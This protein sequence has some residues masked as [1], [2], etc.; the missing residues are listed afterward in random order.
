MC[1]A[2]GAVQHV[3]SEHLGHCRSD[4]VGDDALALRLAPAGRLVGVAARKHDL[5]DR[6]RLRIDPA[7]GE[8]RE[9]RGLLKRRDRFRAER[10]RRKRLEFRGAHAELARHVDDVL[11]ADVERQSRVDG[12]VGLNRR[13]RERL[14]ARVVVCVRLHVPLQRR[15]VERR[16][17][18]VRVKRVDAERDRG[19]EGDR[20][21]RR[22]RLA[23]P[24][25]DEVELVAVGPRSHRGHRANRS[26]ARV[27]R[28]HRARGIGR[29]VQR[30]ADRGSRRT[31][32]PGVNRRVH[33]EPAFAH[34]VRA[35]L[36]LQQILDVAEEVRLA[37]GGVPPSGM[38]VEFPIG[39]RSVVL[40]L[41][42]VVVPEH[43]SKNLIASRES[44]VR[45]NERVV[46][47]R[48]LR[49]AREQRGLV[50]RQ[51][52]RV[53]REVRLRRS[54]DPVRVVA[55]IDLVLVRGEDPVL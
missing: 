30:V 55:V 8:R 16:R 13:V 26:R 5:G 37:N 52:A 11:R 6:H 42:D 50:E 24:A 17:E 27:D 12:V 32:Q 19:R 53:L 54:L 46:Q 1:A 23:R 47:R 4:P 7:R 29:L 38:E 18:V 9:R 2:T 33:L 40:R 43:R 25:R 15:V 20:L 31:L 35:V 44:V 41:R 3:L 22:A 49:Q 21:E 48:R 28:D 14:D 10:D 51:R 39:A 34:G 36:P 45:P